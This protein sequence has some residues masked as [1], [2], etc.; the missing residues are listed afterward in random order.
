MME[1]TAEEQHEPKKSKKTKKDSRTATQKF[2]ASLREIAIVVVI[3]LIVST[4]LKAWVVRSFYIPSASMEDT[5]Q[6]DD[7]IMVNQLPFAH[8]KRGSIVVFNDPGGWLPPGTADEYKPNPF[9]EFVG[10]APSNAGQQLIKRVIGVGG[11]HVECCDDQGR[12]MVNGVAIDETY[13]KPGAPPSETEFS[14]DVPQGHYWV[15][16]DNR[17]NSAD[18]RF[19]GDSEGGP[20]VPEDE[21]VGTVFVISWPTN[22]FSWV[23]APDTF[24]K[25][26]DPS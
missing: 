24:D 6:I 8:P 13:I 21:V 7:R 15:M 1:D 9:L 5:L 20:F 10:L 17:S 16:G 14:V 22:R 25:V 2:L 3:A 26:P 19:N 23:S 12:I 11:D 18:S 4:A